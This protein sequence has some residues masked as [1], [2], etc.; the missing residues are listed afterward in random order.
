MKPSRAEAIKA[1]AAQAQAERITTLE[2]KVDEILD[3]LK[4]KAEKPEKPKKAE[5]PE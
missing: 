2:S 5:K 3:L 1:K 4:G